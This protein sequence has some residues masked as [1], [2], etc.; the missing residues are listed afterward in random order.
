MIRFIA[1]SRPPRRVLG[2]THEAVLGLMGAGPLGTSLYPS[3]SA[4]GAIQVV[5]CGS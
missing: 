3:P 5:L 2:S 1:L 4:E